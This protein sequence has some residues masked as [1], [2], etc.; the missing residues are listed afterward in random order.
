M[1]NS[2]SDDPTNLPRVVRRPRTRLDVLAEKQQELLARSSADEAS[3]SDEN[4]GPL[5]SPRDIENL[6]LRLALTPAGFA[7]RFGIGLRTLLE[8]EQG[9]RQPDLVARSYLRVISVASDAV[10]RALAVE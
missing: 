9:L 3:L 2:G 1:T 6:R 5:F 10:A 7:E 8:W 4:R